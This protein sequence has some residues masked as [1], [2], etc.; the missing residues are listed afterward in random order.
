MQVTARSANA[1]RCAAARAVPGLPWARSMAGAAE[2]RVLK[3]RSGSAQHGG[4]RGPGPG[5]D[6]GGNGGHGWSHHGG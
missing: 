3:A 6:G 2:P 5:W 1:M 4:L